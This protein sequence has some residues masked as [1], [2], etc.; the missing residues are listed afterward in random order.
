[1]TLFS[2]LSISLLSLEERNHLNISKHNWNVISDVCMKRRKYEKSPTSPNRYVINYLPFF[3]LFFSIIEKIPIYFPF[4]SRMFSIFMISINRTAQ[5]IFIST[6]RACYF[7]RFIRSRAQRRIKSVNV[8]RSFMPKKFFLHQ[9]SFSNM[10]N[11]PFG[12]TRKLFSVIDSWSYITR[13][14]WLNCYCLR[15]QLLN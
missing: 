13:I 14:I 15:E 3:L 8:S 7:A 1:M 9:N 6:C 10:K 4:H 11:F 12:K 5:I 2:L